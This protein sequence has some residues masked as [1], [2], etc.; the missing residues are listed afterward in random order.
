MIGFVMLE[1]IT[2]VTCPLTD[3]EQTLRNLSGQQSY[4]GSFIAHW[5]EQLLYYNLPLWVFNTIYISIGLLIL[6]LYFIVPPR[7]NSK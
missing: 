3:L 6:L 2:R 4:T 7:K 5:T 1:I